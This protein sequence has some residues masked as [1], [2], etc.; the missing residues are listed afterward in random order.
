MDHQKTLARPYAKAAFEYALEQK[1]LGEWSTQLALLSAVAESAEI[2]PLYDDPSIA[3]EQLSQ[4]FTGFVDKNEHLKNFV[5]VLSH[6]DRL[7]LL[8]E[9]SALFEDAKAE[10]EKV[11]TVQVTSAFP[12]DDATSKKLKASLTTRLKR[13]V[14]LE[15]EIDKDL[16]GGAVIRAGDWVVDGSVRA[17]LEKLKHAVIN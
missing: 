15:F 16:L 12:M 8:P 11:L 4:I 5:S 7:S 10:H 6:Y 1:K 13:E 2:K 14:N 17:K 9:I 3:A